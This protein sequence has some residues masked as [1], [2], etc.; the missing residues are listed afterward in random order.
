MLKNIL[1]FLL[2]CGF[3]LSGS[4]QTTSINQAKAFAIGPQNDTLWVIEAPSG[5]FSPEDRATA[6][7]KNIEA[8]LEDYDW[9]PNDLLL[10]KQGKNIDLVYKKRALSTVQPEDTVGTSYSQQELA[11]SHLQ[12]VSN[13]LESYS[14]EN[15]LVEWVKKISL[16]VLVLIILAICVKYL[17]RLF[18]W[19]ADKIKSKEGKSI[20][21]I[22]IGEYTLL[23]AET[24]IR[25]YQVLIKLGKLL[26]F[27]L[28]IYLAFPLVF[29]LFPQS[30]ELAKTLIQSILDPLTLIGIG[31]WDFFPNL[32]TILV[33]SLVARYA[34]LGIHY[35]KEEIKT[36]KL[37]LPGFYP[38]WATPTYQ[39]ARVLLIAFTFV[40][41][42]PYLPGS[43]S[44]VF[45][46]V[47]VFLG[48]LF[49]FGSA[50]SLSNIVAGIILTY[51]RLFQVGDRVRI[52][53][54]SGDVVEK[55]MLVTRIRTIKNELI[56]IP[57]S[58]VM[59]SH[60]INYSVDA[61]EKGLILHTT[62]TIGYDVPWREVHQTLLLAAQRTTLILDDPLPFV[63]QTKLDDFYIA[64][65]LN[66]YTK[67]PN[68]Q[69]VIYSELH[70]HIQDCF[71]E[72]NIEIMSP[73]YRAVRE[74]NDSTV[75]NN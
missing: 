2:V 68:Q 61:P 69:A 72:A 10:K 67:N 49:T 66:G 43:D 6:F 28:L 27:A 29:G 70:Q 7:S 50:G 44:P 52:G 73:H 53:D 42:F 37:V 9:N 13:S 12:L 71:K 17:N 30:Q 8:I 74:G 19:I 24:Q 25:I 11:Q 55:N 41:I 21:G 22:N 39:I 31:L 65:Q 35:L 36:G 14:K 20:H 16:A 54:T 26:I 40:V 75:P 1:S 23:D 63:L 56:S 45:Q 38:D 15:T 64:Y 57:N 32:V 62:V 33:I 59:N 48:F 46:G 18:S 60:T 34:L 58:A 5:I 51:M 47:S 4:S 3:Y